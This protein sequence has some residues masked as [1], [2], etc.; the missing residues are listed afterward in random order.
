MIRLLFVLGLAAWLQLPVLAQVSGDRLDIQLSKGV[1]ADKFSLFFHASGNDEIN[2]QDA[3]KVSDGYL[4]L[5]SINAG[6]KKIAIEERAYPQGTQV[7]N[8]FTKVYAAGSY[9]F[10][11]N[12]A[13]WAQAKVAV[14]L[15][16]HLLALN[17]PIDAR[18]QQYSFSLDSNFAAQ[19]NRFSLWLSER[20]TSTE[21]VETAAAALVAYPNP[22]TN[23]LFL[24]VKEE[25][26]AASLQLWDM[27]GRRVWHQQFSH[28]QALDQLEIPCKQLSPGLYLLTWRDHAHP[29]AT[30]TLKIIK[31]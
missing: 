2:D 14:T 8:L 17:T 6:S 11:F 9:Q 21:P 16:D 15:Y 26:A 12:W 18:Q 23:Q 31:R 22:C 20:I 3:P 29:A 28:V 30:T 24:K 13:D 4:S 1:F 5:A 25:T 19:T 10:T 27:Q 7:V